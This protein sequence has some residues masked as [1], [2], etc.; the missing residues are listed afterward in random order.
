MKRRVAKEWLWF[1]SSYAI[2]AW[3]YRMSGG[4][5]FPTWTD[6]A[7]VMAVVYGCRFTVLASMY[8]SKGEK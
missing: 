7:I 6:Y 8:L 3:L 5:P 2:T 1:V 4:P